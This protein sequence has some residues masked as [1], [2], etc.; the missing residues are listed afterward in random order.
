[1]SKRHHLDCGCRPS[2]VKRKGHRPGCEHFDMQRFVGRRRLA[3]FRR[4]WD[5]NTPS[6]DHV[7]AVILAR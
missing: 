7:R 1:M 5:S 4:R 2:T 6:M 3:K